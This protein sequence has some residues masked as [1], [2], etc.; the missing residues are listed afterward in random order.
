M[1]IGSDVAKQQRP[2]RLS[3]KRFMPKEPSPTQVRQEVQAQKE[4]EEQT[5]DDEIREQIRKQWKNVHVTEPVST[6]HKD[7]QVWH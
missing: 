1:K 6:D 4:S 2:K 3:I 7:S 5:K